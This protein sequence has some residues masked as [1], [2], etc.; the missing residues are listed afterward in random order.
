MF[1]RI[2]FGTILVIA[3]ILGYSQFSHNATLNK[4]NESHPDFIL[5]RANAGNTVVMFFDYNS[6]WSR[7][8]QPVL[9]QLISRN[10]NTRVIVREL[11]GI[12]PMSETISRVA[13][14]AR[15]KGRYKEIYS[16]LMNLDVE[17]DEALLRQVV[18]QLGMDYDE[19]L[20]IGRGEEVSRL[21]RENQ[22]A[23]T[24]LGIN[25]APSF[26]V[27][28]RVMPGGG[29]TAKDFNR[30]ITEVNKQR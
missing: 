1:L 22:Q 2:V 9:M 16:F 21:L 15:T 27:Q 17:I 7:R 8:S 5:G 3:M 30:V 12:T 11:P 4:L 28:G 6:K 25:S 19:L 24:F 13:L 23:A 29:Y 18:E 26:V 10:P 14:A 20:E